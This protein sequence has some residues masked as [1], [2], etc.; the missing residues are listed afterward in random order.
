MDRD[1]NRRAA[2]REAV[3]G[4]DLRHHESRQEEDL[5]HDEDELRVQRIE[6][7]LRAGTREREAGGWG[8]ESRYAPSVSRLGYP[9]GTKKSPVIECR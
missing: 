4:E 3:R 1:Q 8:S 7:E 9:L 2:R 6:E 5:S